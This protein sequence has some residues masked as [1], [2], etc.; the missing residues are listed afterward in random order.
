MA[1]ARSSSPA[2]AT[3]SE[4]HLAFDNV[5]GAQSVDAAIAGATYPAAARSVVVL[6]ERV[7]DQARA[8]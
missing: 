3:R 1:A 8:W 4:R 7:A 5:A 6:F 2:R